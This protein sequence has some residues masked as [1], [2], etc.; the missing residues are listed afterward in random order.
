MS[1]VG[2]CVAV[3]CCLCV[4]AGC[5]S[6]VS[7]ARDSAPGG[8]GLGP[9]REVKAFRDPYQ[10][11]VPAQTVPV[12]TVPVQ[13]VPVQS[14]RLYLPHNF[15]AFGP[16]PVNVFCGSE[17]E[18]ALDHEYVFRAERE[19][20][21]GRSYTVRSLCIEIERATGK[22]LV[23]MPEPGADLLASRGRRH[24]FNS[25][26]QLG[27]VEET[28]F[29]RVCRRPLGAVLSHL[30]FE[31]TRNFTQGNDWLW[32]AWLGRDNIFLVRLPRA[33]ETKRERESPPKSS[34]RTPDERSGDLTESD[35]HEADGTPESVMDIPAVLPR[36]PFN[37]EVIRPALLP[38]AAHQERLRQEVRI[39]WC[40]NN[41]W[42]ISKE[43]ARSTG[44]S[45]I[46]WPDP[47]TVEPAEKPF[48]WHSFWNPDAS[49]AGPAK[50]RPPTVVK[51]TVKGV[52][53]DLISLATEFGMADEAPDREVWVALL[54][55][56]AFFFLMLP[57]P[58]W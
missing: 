7:Q 57:D 58:Y 17:A 11:G 12:Q 24:V 6:V 30:A 54:A 9:W 47:A 16:W 39:E 14:V 5:R 46:W 18:A 44:L 36:S 15:L 25:P 35:A 32:T 4:G 43:L 13:T 8:L 19:F 22:R 23:W 56:D 48:G 37:G 10:E 28:P 27:P 29:G 40:P 26:L 45:T 50:R 52:L 21:L 38:I 20:A 1:R 49:S 41:L 34:H 3:F 2:W 42:V 55:E 33:R 51:R 31:L 53:E